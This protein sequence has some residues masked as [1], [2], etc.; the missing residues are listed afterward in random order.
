MNNM[1]KIAII[2]GGRSVEHEVSIVTALQCYTAIKNAH[3]PIMIYLDRDNVPRLCKLRSKDIKGA[4][5]RSRIIDLSHLSDYTM[6]NCCHGGIGEGGEL[7]AILDFYGIKYTNAN[8]LSS[9]LCMDKMLTKTCLKAH[10]IPL[11]P[12]KS[13]GKLPPLNELN[14]LSYPVIVKPQHLG[15]S[16]CV[17]KCMD[18]HMASLAIDAALEYD[19]AVMVERCIDPLIEYNCA[20]FRSN[21]KYIVSDIEQPVSHGETLSFSDK[22][23][24]KSKHSKG[25][26]RLIPAPISPKLKS[27]IE[28]L[29]QKVYL[30]LGLKGVVRVDYLYDRRNGKLYLNEINT[31][32]GSLAFYLFE[33]KGISYVELVDMLV[34]EADCQNEE[35]ITSFDSHIL[36]FAL[37]KK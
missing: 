9:A 22:Y 20:I 19:S 27:Q 1:K 17:Q 29:T 14:R 8:C 36:D 6:I 35:K 32:P 13:Y 2:F 23:L 12:A 21:G 34:N 18:A 5:K 10:K 11:I 30:L 33:S 26:S 15:S 31:V 24:S 16:I 3:K 7:S 28:H 37:H 4:I 25:N